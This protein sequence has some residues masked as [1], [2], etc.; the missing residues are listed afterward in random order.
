M[1]RARILAL[2][3]DVLVCAAPAD[4]ASLLLTWALWR[5]FP[6]AR[7][8]IP[9]L[10]IAAAAVASAAFLLRDAR[11]GRARR[12][13]GLEIR[14][15][16]GSPPG[17]S[18]SIRRNLALLIPLWNVWDAWPVFRDGESPRR[19]DRRAGLRMLRIT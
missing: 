16:D 11:G 10:W 1:R 13:L 19:S 2:F 18:G 17:A 5:F 3:I 6:A 9:A 8:L 7:T 12:W 14:R 15:A 4:L